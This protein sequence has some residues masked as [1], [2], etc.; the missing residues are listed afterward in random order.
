MLKKTGIVVA[1]S[2]AGLLAMSPLAFASDGHHHG[3]HDRSG[4]TQS[5]LINLQNT[6]AQIPVQLCNNSVLEGALGVLASHQKNSDS[7][8]GHCRQHNSAD[9]GSDD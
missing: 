8:K 3:H 5:G 7:H 6:N 1:A 2:A 4:N 9:N